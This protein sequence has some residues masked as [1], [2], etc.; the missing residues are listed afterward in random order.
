MIWLS[1][2][3]SYEDRDLR[4]ALCARVDLRLRA[5]LPPRREEPSF[6]HP[7]LRSF[8]VLTAPLVRSPHSLVAWLDFTS[9]MNQTT[10]VLGDLVVVWRT[11]F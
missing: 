9:W 6:A 8:S 11:G 5:H 4:E 2:P 10:S 7:I 1:F 3:S